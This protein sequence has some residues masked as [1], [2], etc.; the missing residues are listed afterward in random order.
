MALPNVKKYFYASMLMACLEWRKMPETDLTLIL[1][2]NL[3]KIKLADWM[4]QDTIAKRDLRTLNRT[5]KFLGTSWLRH[6]EKL[7]HPFSPLQKCADQQD[8]VHLGPTYSL[9]GQQWDLLVL[10]IY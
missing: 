10:Q 9:D 8:F 2:Q 6:R 7:F 4:F 3:S 1:E 5:A